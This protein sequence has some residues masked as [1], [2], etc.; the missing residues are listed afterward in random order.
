MQ[1]GKKVVTLFSVKTLVV[2]DLKDEYGILTILLIFLL[3]TKT[4]Y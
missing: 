2:G 3:A 4:F 1:M